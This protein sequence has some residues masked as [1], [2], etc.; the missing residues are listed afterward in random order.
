MRPLKRVI[1]SKVY[2]EGEDNSVFRLHDEGTSN[3]K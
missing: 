3:C 2:D 1:G